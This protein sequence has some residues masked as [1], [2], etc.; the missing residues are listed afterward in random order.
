ML[1]ETSPR[2][3]V[4]QILQ[5][6]SNQFPSQ[7]PSQQLDSPPSYPGLQTNYQVQNIDT[8]SIQKKESPRKE[9]PGEFPKI[10]LCKRNSESP[11]SSPRSA[12]SSSPSTSSS[13]RSDAESAYT[14]EDTSE[15]SLS[16]ATLTPNSD[17]KATDHQILE[18]SNNDLFMNRILDST[19]NPIELNNIQDLLSLKDLQRKKGLITFDELKLRTVIIKNDENMLVDGLSQYLEAN[20]CLE[21]YKKQILKITQLLIFITIKI[22]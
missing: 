1:Q 19:T 9:S 16:D 20:K 17:H 22:Q 8:T 14:S 21:A 15:L 3:T 11:N 18:M 13:P 4:N 10:D 5:Q 6:T 2:S 7:F 12:L